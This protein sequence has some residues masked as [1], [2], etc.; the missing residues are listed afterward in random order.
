MCG[1]SS[2][3]YIHINNIVLFFIRTLLYIGEAH[4]IEMSGVARIEK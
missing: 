2:V 1:I 3:I 4:N